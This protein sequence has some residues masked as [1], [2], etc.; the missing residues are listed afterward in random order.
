MVV[1]AISDCFSQGPRR[2][3][4]VDISELEAMGIVD[5]PV[6]DGIGKGPLANRVMPAIDRDLAGDQGA[7]AAIAVFKNLEEEMALRPGCRNSRNSAAKVMSFADNFLQKQQKQRERRVQKGYGGYPFRGP[8]RSRNLM[9][10]TAG[11]AP[12]CVG[13]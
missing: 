3:L 1:S 13:R 9:Y 6:E 7:A 8:R 10:R 4:Q 5:D 11:L 2:L 12:F